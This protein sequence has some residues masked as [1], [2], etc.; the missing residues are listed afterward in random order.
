MWNSTCSWLSH[1]IPSTLLPSFGEAA[2]ARG[3]AFGIGT[4]SGPAEPGGGAGWI[5]STSAALSVARLRFIGAL[6]TV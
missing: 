1:L 4:P 6:V 5:G 3:G 2:A